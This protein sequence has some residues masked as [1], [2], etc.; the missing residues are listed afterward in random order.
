M[1]GHRI[2]VSLRSSEPVV[3]A[4]DKGQKQQ[5]ETRSDRLQFAYDP[6]PSSCAWS[7]CI[8]L[9]GLCARAA[10]SGMPRH[11][12]V[13]PGGGSRR[14]TS[15]P[16][17]SCLTGW[18]DLARSQ[19]SVAPWTKRATSSG[20]ATH[21]CRDG[22]LERER[23]GLRHE[24]EDCLKVDLVFDRRQPVGS[25]GLEQLFRRVGRTHRRVA[26]MYQRQARRRK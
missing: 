4:A 19:S 23:N 2:P 18:P 6:V 5:P 13:D 9:A 15:P 1:K 25:R 12:A 21:E 3:Q 8:S 16:P 26:K 14:C 11:E 7:P 22:H 24:V 10:C 17:L 20:L